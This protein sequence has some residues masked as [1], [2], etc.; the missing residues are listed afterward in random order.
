MEEPN[1]SR[2][3]I[4][5][6][7]LVGHEGARWIR[8]TLRAV[9]DQDRPV[10]R[11]VAVDTGSTDQ[12]SRFLVDA[13]GPGAVL[14]LPPAT[15]FGAAVR[16]GLRHVERSR[17]GGAAGPDGRDWVWLLH[18][19]SAPQPDAL[20]Q[21]LAAADATPA[22]AV[23][24]PKLRGWHDANLLLEVGTTI[25]WSG[26]RSTGL[27]P[28]E[29]DQGQHDGRRDVLAVSSAGMLVRRDVW[30][31]LGGFDPNLPLFRDDID[32][33]WRVR[34]AG[35]QVLCATD[36][37]VQHAEAGAR[38]RRALPAV[39][40]NGHR[41]D[42]RAALH[43]LLANLPAAALPLA[44][45]R[46]TLGSLARAAGFLLAKLPERAANEVLA[47]L[48]VLLR[49]DRLWQA[50]RARWRTRAHGAAAVTPLLASS[51]APLR[52]AAEATVARLTGGAD[53]GAHARTTEAGPTSEAA[54]D[55]AA[56][57]AVRGLL[58]RPPALLV[59]GLVILAAIACRDLIGSGRL[60]GG[61]LL[62]APAGAGDLWATYTASWHG[63]G[64]GSDSAAP[65]YVA[66]LAGLAGVLFGKAGLAVDVVLLGCVPLAGLTAYIALAAAVR[67]TALR[68]WG[69]AAYATLPVATGAVAGGRVG[70]A[71]ALVL[72]PL[73][74][75]ATGRLLAARRAPWSRAWLCGLLLALVTAF[76]PLAYLVAALLGLAAT[77][78][79]GRRR[80]VALR[81]LVIL[82]VPPGLLLPWTLAVW[83]DPAML[84]REP[85]VAD[86]RL[87]DADLNPLAVIL[88]HP[89]GPGMYQ[90]WFSAGLL[91]AAI[92]ALLRPD[93]RRL[94]AAAW[95]TALVGLLVA[96]VLTRLEI[97]A[98]SV[99]GTT[100]AWPGFA[101]AVA[102]AGLVL[103]AVVGGE[104]LAV[105]MPR[106]RFGPWQPVAFVAAAAA[107]LAPALAGAAW[108][109][110]GADGPIE[111][112]DAA[113]LPAYVA[114][115]AAMP[116]RPRTLVLSV[117]A[118]GRVNYAVV[119]GGGPELGAADVARAA[120]DARLLDVAVA[121]VVSGRGRDGLDRL[122]GHAVRFIY[123]SRPVEPGLVSQLETLPGLTRVGAP[124][125]AALWRLDRPVSQLQIVAPG[126]AG[127][128]AQSPL[129][130]GERGRVLALAERA[131]PGWEASV[132]GR[133]LIPITVDGWAQGFVLPES[134]G[135]L[136]LGH[137]PE[138]RNRW[139][140]AQGCVLLV[141]LVLAVPSARASAARVRQTRAR[142]GRP[143]PG[144][145]VGPP[146]EIRSRAERRV[147][148]QAEWSAERRVDEQAVRSIADREALP[149]SPAERGR[150]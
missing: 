32:F 127:E 34:A 72:L 58:R 88:L 24:G 22:A 65:P 118:G 52:S 45:V 30:D 106:W 19:D 13:L 11:L 84:L 112:G 124:E 6:A 8:A 78:T 70:T 137:D 134:G 109:V 66:V 92:A 95:V 148:E 28:R 68:L 17:P 138:G 2:R 77:L 119:R 29:V 79:F 35:H 46:L 131:D 85:G 16:G 80:G 102:G 116:S 20:R 129:P 73:L 139:L 90:V 113:L 150:R 100:A 10:D 146:S 71:A 87:T 64:L 122:A 76:A 120:D 128:T 38:D 123:A 3:H 54:D 107:A 111:R 89:G 43:V 144:G 83:Q 99:N 50:R 9:A 142:R 145:G 15:G 126:S 41:A 143:L 40:G 136:H 51:T 74:A 18:D 59:A 105:R 27:D 62:P 12:T 147:D 130:A 56:G 86:S 21:L 25:A 47:L 39:G 69:A 115:E 4:V 63:V 1:S 121:D 67:P 31:A 108:V 36:A 57:H 114:A 96:L 104:G 60:F 44:V 33:C 141:V 98:P 23:I 140:L 117:R 94:L 75:R 101:T 132:N 82:A 81:I 14:N 93:R 48:A 91:L 26:R 110:R 103:A 55:L 42:R 125:G 133:P 53:G 37:I 135:L 5:T 7:L 61:A 49:P 149:R 97:P